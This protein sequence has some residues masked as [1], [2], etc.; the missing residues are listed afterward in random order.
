MPIH[1]K[2]KQRGRWDWH[3]VLRSGSI[4]DFPLEDG[5]TSLKTQFELEYWPAAA[6]T[7]YNG[8]VNKKPNT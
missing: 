5:T 8:R 2:H 6:D 1:W 7:Q 3:G 4:P